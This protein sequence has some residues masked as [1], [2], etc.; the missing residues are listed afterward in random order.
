M[1]N[2]SDVITMF[3]HIHKKVIGNAKYKFRANGNNIKMVNNF[4]NKLTPSYGEQ[5][6]TDVISFG[7]F[8]Y[9]DMDTKFGKGKMIL[10]GWILGDK[11]IKAFNDAS[12]EQRFVFDQFKAK[13]GIHYQ[14]QTVASIDMNAYGINERK[15]F[16]NTDRGFIHCKE[17][18]LTRG[19]NKYCLMCNYKEYCN[20]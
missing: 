3:E 1:I 11:N 16:Y 4:C 9:H 13:Y 7:F 10:V 19:K 5:W 6:L 2:S 20:D 15:R 12:A 8:R 18:G 14:E 17:M